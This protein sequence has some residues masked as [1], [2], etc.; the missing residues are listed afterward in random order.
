MTFYDTILLTL[1]KKLGIDNFIIET[2]RDKS[3]GDF[4]TAVAMQIGKAE[5]KNP[6]EVASVLLPKIQGIDFVE[7][8]SVAGPGFINIK[9]KNEFILKNINKRF[10]NIRNG[11][12]IDLDYGSYNVAKELHIGN[13][14]TSIVGDTFYR[15][16]KF[17]GFKPISYNYIGDWGRPIAMIIAWII[18]N[19]FK[20]TPKK[21]N[22]FYPA[23]SL[24]AKDHPEFIEL[25]QKIKKEFQDGKPEYVAIYE[26]F[27][28]ISL[29]MMGKVIKRLN[30]LPFDNNLGEKNA[31]KYVRDVEKILRDKKLLKMDDGAMIVE[32][33]RDSD[34]APMPPFMFY[35]S[36]G[37][38]T[39]DTTDLATIYYRKITDNPDKMIYF[40]D[41]RQQLHFEQL[42][43]VAEMSGIFSSENLEHQYFGAITGVDGK[44]FKTRDG[45]V[46]TLSDI[47][48]TVE[49]AV[50][51]R[52]NKLSEKTIKMIALAALKF[53][54]LMHDMKSDY[55]FDPAAVTSF[56]GRTGPYILYTAVRLNS[57]LEK[58]N[59]TT[60]SLRATP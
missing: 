54:D 34:T 15:I 33:K 36:R 46:A 17:L 18:K 23:A 47:V 55:V 26:K 56:E 11:G 19:N 44:P 37:A 32:L 9:I 5:G 28:K 12:I 58:S 20:I 13:L 41:V 30:M 40:T 38:D 2:P 25:V 50:K 24:Y 27:L 3:F 10:K 39:Y 22:S 6:R 59:T 16:A 1:K 43:R 21:L 29:N 53:N 42:F 49:E 48:D 35:D 51:K 8:A 57:V 14:R 60:P 45:N 7:S 4:A 52:E 31:S